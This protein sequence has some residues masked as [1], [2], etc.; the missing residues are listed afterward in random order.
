MERDSKL[1]ADALAAATELCEAAMSRGHRC[2]GCPLW[3]EA[4]TV[5]QKYDHYGK[6]RP[7]ETDYCIIDWL[8][9]RAEEN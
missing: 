9:E 3:V 1:A 7:E 8:S 5:D 2:E 6:V 4:G